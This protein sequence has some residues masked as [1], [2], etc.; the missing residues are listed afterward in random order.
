MNQR[1]LAVLL[2]FFHRS[3]PGAAS[4]I[5]FSGG[6]RLRDARPPGEA[7]KSILANLMNAPL[8]HSEKT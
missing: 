1:P 3:P 7:V 4:I 8:Q 2:L 5:R 6:E